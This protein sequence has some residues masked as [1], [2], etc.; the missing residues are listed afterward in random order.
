MASTIV[1]PESLEVA[2]AADRSRCVSAAPHLSLAPTAVSPDT[3]EACRG[4]YEMAL[5]GEIIGLAFVAML[6]GKQYF[7]DAV[8]KALREPTFTRGALLSLNDTLR[9]LIAAQLDCD[10]GR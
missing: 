9:G 2:K 8:A 3:I 6:P 7:V 4:L 10:D 1:N 5:R